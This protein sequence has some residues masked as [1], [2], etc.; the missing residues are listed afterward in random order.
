MHGT[1]READSS[2]DDQGP[3]SVPCLEFYDF[4]RL[5]GVDPAIDVFYGPNPIQTSGT[6]TVPRDLK[7]EIGLEPGSRVHWALNPDIPGTLILV[8]ATLLSRAMPSA[9]DALRPLGQ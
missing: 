2:S 4:S 6:V 5:V 8:P 1:N 3:M 7:R 9:L